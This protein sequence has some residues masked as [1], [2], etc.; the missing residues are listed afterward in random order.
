[1]LLLSTVI[2]G[3]TQET[4]RGSEPPKP[5]LTMVSDR[6]IEIPVK[7]GSYAWRSVVD[8][9]GPIELLEGYETVTLPSNSKL[10]IKFDYKPRPSSIRISQLIVDGTHNTVEKK[11]QNNVLTLSGE[12]GTHI[13]VIDARWGEK[14]QEVDAQATYYFQVEVVD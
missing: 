2:I 5:T 10:E 13:Y 14:G 9:I 8:K 7:L 11:V 6:K 12:I 3:C 4:I 1:M